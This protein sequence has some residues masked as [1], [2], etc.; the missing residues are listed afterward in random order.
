M[1]VQAL[2]SSVDRPTRIPL[3]GNVE[4]VS[5]I[6]SLRCTSC[7]FQYSGHPAILVILRSQICGIVVLAE[8]PVE[9]SRE[10]DAFFAE[11]SLYLLSERDHL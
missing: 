7:Q 3:V 1:S 2:S 8:K 10:G 5:F 6:S 9:K 4:L 11:P